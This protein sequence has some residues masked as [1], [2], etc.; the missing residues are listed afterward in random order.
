VAY[1]IIAVLLTNIQT[2]IGNSNNWVSNYF[3]YRPPTLR[4]YLGSVSRADSDII[5][6]DIV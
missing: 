3:N 1:Y 5:E 4:E 2:C 6:E